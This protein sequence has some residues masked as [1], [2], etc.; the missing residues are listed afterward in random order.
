MVKVKLGKV[1]K[2]LPNQSRYQGALTTSHTLDSS[3]PWAR[4]CL[5]LGHTFWVIFSSYESENKLSNFQKKFLRIKRI[6]IYPQI[7]HSWSG[8]TTLLQG[9]E[10]WRCY[11]GEP[12]RVGCFLKALQLA[13][14][15]A[16]FLPG[17]WKQVC[18]ERGSV[19]A[20]P[21]VKGKSWLRATGGNGGKKKK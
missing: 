1:K 9:K 2:N 10:H 17:A 11:K 13:E 21:R 15:P 16:G 8:N 19:W 14:V 7:I 3:K 20:R 4:L 6:E 12:Q 18:T 5:I